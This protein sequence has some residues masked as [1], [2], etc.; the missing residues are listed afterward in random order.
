MFGFDSAAIAAR[1]AKRAEI[2]A[3]IA[4]LQE[5][6]NIARQSKIELSK[7][8]VVISNLLTEWGNSLKAFESG[9]MAA[10]VVPDRFEGETAEKI[11]TRLPEPISEMESTNSSALG[12]QAEIAEQLTKLDTYI[13]ELEEKKSVLYA[14]LAAI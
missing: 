4:V 7:I 14:Q 1:N 10:V 8:N 2:R 11:S 6:I 12:V 13:N 5:Q 9:A 3:A